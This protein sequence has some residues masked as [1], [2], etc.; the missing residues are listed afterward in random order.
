M[1]RIANSVQEVEHVRKI[2]QD[3]QYGIHRIKLRNGR[4]LEG[5]ILIGRSGNTAGR[6]GSWGC[7]GE[8]V[9]KQKDGREITV[10]VLDIVSSQNM[11]DQLSGEYEKLGLIEIVN[12][13]GALN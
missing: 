12:Y 4:D 6:G 11:W 1:A 8:I 2:M 5:V 13:P 10:D 7:W 3:L 9:L